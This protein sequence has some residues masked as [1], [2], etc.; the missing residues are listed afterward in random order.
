MNCLTWTFTVIER[1]SYPSTINKHGGLR[2]SLGSFLK[3][4]L[5]VR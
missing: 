2:L 1:L 4:D 5:D 3:K